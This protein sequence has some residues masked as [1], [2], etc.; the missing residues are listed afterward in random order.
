MFKIIGARNISRSAQGFTLIELM[1]TV[2]I[3][4]ILAAIAYPAYTGYVVRGNRSAA[5]ALLMNIAQREQQY[6]LDS[7]SYADS[8]T[9]GVTVPSNVTSYYTI[10]IDLPVSP[11]PKF[12]ATAT[13]KLGTMQANDGTLS[14]DQAGLK[15]PSALW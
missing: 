3:L 4:G 7:R 9:L 5:Q 15:S 13:P 2:A 12:T 1:I 8:T 10:A 11:Q 6:L 14:I